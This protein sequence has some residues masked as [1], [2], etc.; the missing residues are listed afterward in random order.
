M[1]PVLSYWCKMDFKKRK[2]IRNSWNVVLQKNA[3]AKLGEEKDKRKHIVRTSHKRLTL[4]TSKMVFFRWR[5]A[6]RLSPGVG[7]H[8][9][10]QGDKVMHAR[11]MGVKS[12]RRVLSD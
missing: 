11:T 7:C 6:A 5:G 9:T 3:V 12:A 10:T 2:Q 8:S 1:C 4:G